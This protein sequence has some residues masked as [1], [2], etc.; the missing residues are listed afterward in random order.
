VN[1]K[2]G[3]FLLGW[4]V[5]LTCPIAGVCQTIDGRGQISGWLT[6]H[7]DRETEVQ[8]GIRALPA[9]SIKKSFGD[10]VAL[11]AE[12]SFNAY[13]MAAARESRGSS[14]D[15][16]IK[17]YRLWARL[18]TPRFEARLGL[19]KINFG[20][21]LL[22]RPLMWFDRIDPNDP[23]QLTDGVYGALAKYTFVSNANIWIWGLYGNEDAKGWES[24]PTKTKTPEFGGRFQVPLLSGEAAFTFH[25][26]LMD[27]LKSLIALP[28]G[29]RE[30]IPENRFALDGKWDIGAGVWFE[31]AL[32]HQ[33][34]RVHP[35]KYQRNLN[36][37]ADYT[38]GIGNG[39][40]VIA[41]HLIFVSSEKALGAGDAVRFTAVSADCPLGLLDRIKGIVFHNWKTGDWYR[42]ITWQRTCDKW[43]FL[44]IGF[45]NPD[46]YQIYASQQGKN[47]FA[48]KG[49]QIMA[50][51]NY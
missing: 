25:H 50:V 6:L 7:D 49:I 18:S 5:L 27:P 48:G 37:G 19:Q 40:H 17:P 43:S 14:T 20:S 47:L 2:V 34:F 45:W 42:L 35:L 15:G 13:G 23:L 3:G 28:S 46:R 29:E 39:V 38:F 31:A 32:I 24:V 33:D 10:K 41:E 11:D 4:A 30:R 22:L 8:I 16:Q 51:F 36:L 26:R 12:V 21:A 1:R 44:A 9:F